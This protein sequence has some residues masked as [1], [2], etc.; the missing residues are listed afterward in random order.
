MTEIQIVGKI[1]EWLKT[2]PFS[3]GDTKVITGTDWNDRGEDFGQG[4]KAVL[5]IDGSPLYP[6]FNYGEP[7][8]N[9]SENFR[10]F[11][12]RLGLWYEMMHAW[13]IAIYPI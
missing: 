8:W 4:A 1:E 2:L 11:L 9:I 10:E 7:S 13:S 5:L 6:I 12:D 3:L